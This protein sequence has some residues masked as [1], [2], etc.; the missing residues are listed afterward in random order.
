VRHHSQ[1]ASEKDRR[2]IFAPGHTIKGVGEG[3]RVE[4]N[5]WVSN[6]EVERRLET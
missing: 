6:G 4:I 3:K 5:E 2:K 1:E